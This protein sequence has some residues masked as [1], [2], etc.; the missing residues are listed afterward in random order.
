MNAGL[1]PELIIAPKIKGLW[2]RTHKGQI[3]NPTTNEAHADTLAHYVKLLSVIP[4][5]DLSIVMDY[6]E[7]YTS[8]PTALDYLAHFRREEETLLQIEYEERK[9]LEIS[10][11]GDSVLAVMSKTKSP[12]G[13][14]ICSIMRKHMG[15]IDN[16][17]KLQRPKIKFDLKA[18]REEIHEL[19]RESGV[20]FCD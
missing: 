15:F 20:T 5:E 12:F 1:N 7:N 16:N 6:F 2:M 3:L 9:R 13:Q 18:Y 17:G 19:M 11:G 14:A 4:L 10:R 8:M